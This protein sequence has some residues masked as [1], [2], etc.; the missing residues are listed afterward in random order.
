M[1][2]TI[3]RLKKIEKDL[4]IISVQT[5]NPNFDIIFKEKIIKANALILEAKKEIVDA[6][7]YLLNQ[8]PEP[9]KRDLKW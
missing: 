9:E 3:K 1:I 4:I 5:Q 7:Y 2:D 8:L 6:E